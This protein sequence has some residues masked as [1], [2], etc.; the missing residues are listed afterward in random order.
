MGIPSYYKRLIDRNPGL[1]NRKRVGTAK[2]SLYFDFNCLVYQCLH[3]KSLRPY[4]GGEEW[5][6]E[7]LNLVCKYVRH[8]Y[9]EAGNPADVF[10]AV[11]G[12]VPMAKIRQQRMRRFKSVWLAAEEERVGA[13]AY[14]DGSM[15]WDTNAITPGTA[16]MDRLAVRLGELC[17]KHGWVLS[18]SHSPGEGEQKI[19]DRIRKLPPSGDVIVYGLDGDLILL[20]LLG[21]E[22][23]SACQRPLPACHGPP[24][25]CHGP[26]PAW[27]L[28]REAGDFGIAGA[29]PDEFVFLDIQMLKGI[30]CKTHTIENYVCAMSLLGNDFVPHSLSVKLRD[31]GHDILLEAIRGKELVRDGV[32]QW[33]AFRE[34][35]AKWAHEESDWI[36]AGFAHK[37]KMRPGPTKNDYDRLMLDVTNLPVTWAAE[38][39]VWSVESGLLPSWKAGYRRWCYDSGQMCEEYMRGLQWVWDYYTGRPVDTTWYYA[40]F[41]PPLWSDLLRAEEPALKNISSVAPIQE[42]EQLAM[43]LPEKSW[44]LIRDRPLSS[45]LSRAS[46]FWPTQFRFFSVGRRWFW[47]CEAIVPILSIHR[48]RELV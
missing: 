25:A 37:Y 17:A 13:R 33:P 16:F 26:L 11:D 34:I 2:V 15:R 45:L 29:K 27:H 39:E 40:W 14:V 41:L 9:A 42:Q 47:E 7:L 43:V 24:S 32:L 38:K 22:A 20:S 21:L 8:V 48:L 31:G 1:V 28:M 44:G 12:V 46:V 5:E 3:D 6:G 23:P 10:I 30:L 36:A 18:D 4:D 35:W 19:M